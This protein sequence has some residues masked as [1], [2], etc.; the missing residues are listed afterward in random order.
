MKKTLIILFAL[1]LLMCGCKKNSKVLNENGK[2][3]NPQ[4]SYSSSEQSSASS[5]AVE[6]GTDGVVDK[7]A[8]SPKGSKKEVTAS[9]S[10]GNQIKME[11]YT[12][13]ELS[14]SS[15]E[16]SNTSEKTNPID[17]DGDGYIDGHY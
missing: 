4:P 2:N 10:D 6:E 3:S 1:F 8:T 14:E 13:S 7:K 16:E 5:D 15:R 11:T 17:K 9:D 12:D